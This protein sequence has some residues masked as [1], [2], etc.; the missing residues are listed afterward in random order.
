MNAN[1]IRRGDIFC[2]DFGEKKGSVQGGYRPVLVLQDTNSCTYS[3]TVVVAAI[4]SV[5]KKQYLPTHV[6]LGSNF[7]LIC[8]SMVLLEQ[9]QTVNKKDLGK[10]IGSI[11]DPQ[12]W[13]EINKGISKIL[14]AQPQRQVSGNI[15]CLCSKCRQGY[16]ENSKYIVRRVD[17][18]SKEKKACDKCGQLG[19][20]Y[21]LINKQPKNQ[22]GAS[23][24]EKD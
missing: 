13:M 6:V 1:V 2:F 18:L 5:M 15:R 22:K 14:R 20:D 23:V 21:L 17:P 19:Y 4:T 16:I 24:D 3:P 8:P 12:I 11:D 10:Y 9:M 7:G